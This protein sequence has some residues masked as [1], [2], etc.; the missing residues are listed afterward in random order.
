M[1][2]LP[3][4]EQNEPILIES[5]RNLPTEVVNEYPSSM[6]LLSCNLPMNK[7]HDRHKHL[8]LHDK[9]LIIPPNETS[10]SFIRFSVKCT[11]LD[12]SLEIVNDQ[13]TT[14]Y[15]IRITK[16]YNLVKEREPLIEY[17][18]V[19]VIKQTLRLFHN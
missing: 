19:K 5:Y 1:K 14:L 11:L 8:S 9:Q 10:L 13:P 12:S 2:G 15:R 7:T 16:H 17:H 18:D 3:K 4:Y 6:N